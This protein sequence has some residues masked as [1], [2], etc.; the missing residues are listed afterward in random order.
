M[1]QRV[2]SRD[3]WLKA[4]IELLNAEKE[5]SRARD[6]L[7]AQRRE[8]PSVEV[9]NYTFDG[10]DGA[11]SL[12]DLFDGRS[13][14]IVYHFMFDPEWDAGCKSCSFVTDHFQNALVHLAH[15]DVTLVAVSRAPL[16]KLDAYAARMGWSHRWVSS[17]GGSFNYD[18]G[19]SFTP[20]QIEAAAPYN[21]GTGTGWGE[22][23][24][25]SVFLRDGD[26]ILHTYSTYSRGLDLLI[27]T[28]NYLDLVPRGRNYDGD[29][30]YM[31]WLRRRDEYG[32]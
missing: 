21:Y 24:G 5:F 7:S 20:Q 17:L 15:R 32:D 14:L 13:Q 29:D 2:V 16:D 28:Y 27:N 19:V 25:L 11:V 30:Q 1:N 23:P 22:A 9:P 10:A 8:L 31:G 6:A 12:A 26:R 3:E 18:F 4:R